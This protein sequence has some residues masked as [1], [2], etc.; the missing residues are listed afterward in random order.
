MRFPGIAE[1]PETDHG[2]VNHE[3]RKI[4]KVRKTKAKVRGFRI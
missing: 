2:R 3:A 1:W 4:R